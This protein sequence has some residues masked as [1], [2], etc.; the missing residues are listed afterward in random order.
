VIARERDRYL[1][2]DSLL[3]EWVVGRTH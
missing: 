2:I 1:V 3:R